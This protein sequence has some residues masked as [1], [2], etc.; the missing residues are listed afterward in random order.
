MSWPT[1][2]ASAPVTWAKAAPKSSASDSSHWSGTTP[3]TSYAFT[4]CDRSAA[5]ANLPEVL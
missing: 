1:T 4:I 5:T 3:R 2:I